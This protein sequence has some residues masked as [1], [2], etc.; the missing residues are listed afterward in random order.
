[1]RQETTREEAAV[2]DLYVQCLDLEL[3]FKQGSLG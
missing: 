3:M 1:M 2:K